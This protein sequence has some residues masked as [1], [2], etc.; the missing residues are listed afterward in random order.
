[1]A[2]ARPPL[3][4][5][6]DSLHSPAAW[7]AVRVNERLILGMLPDVAR[8][9]RASWNDRQLALL[10]VLEGR[11]RELAGDAAA[12]EGRRH[13]GVHEY[14]AA[15][16]VRIPDQREV[17]LDADLELP[18]L[19]VVLHHQAVDVTIAQAASSLVLLALP[20]SRR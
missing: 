3:H 12:F 8:H 17:A 20:R 14:D 4:P 15:V 13:L 1:M 6:G 9:E 7:S 11:A 5:T 19:F 16:R 2:V 18:R 10:R